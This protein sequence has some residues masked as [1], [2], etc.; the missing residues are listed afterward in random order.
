MLSDL[1]DERLVLL[2]AEASNWE[3]AVR[4]S[5]RPMVDANK[6][7]EGYIDAVISGIHELGPYIVI[8]EHVAFPHAR[9][10]CGA[11]QT[12][13]GMVTLK[14][15]VEFGSEINDPVKF[16]FPLAATDSNSHIDALRSL[17]QLLND[18]D[19]FTQLEQAQ[20]PQEVIALV[21]AKEAA[22]E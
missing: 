19:F 8:T 16:L 9:P 20:T 18:E 13:V 6:I 1:I 22:M 5:M 14:E 17:V 2:N 10:E 3:D 21:K 7:T 12:A 4:V 11:L 15:P